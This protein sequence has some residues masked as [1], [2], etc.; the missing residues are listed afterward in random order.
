MHLIKLKRI[1]FHY[2][3]FVTVLNCGCNLSVAIWFGH[4]LISDV[5]YSTLILVLLHDHVAGYKLNLASKYVSA[6]HQIMNSSYTFF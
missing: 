4:H 3:S 5:T 6:T 2:P 1:L